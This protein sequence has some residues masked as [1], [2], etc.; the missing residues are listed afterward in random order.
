[1]SKTKEKN[2]Q[3]IICKIKLFKMPYGASYDGHFDSK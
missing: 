3:E 1:M 2:K